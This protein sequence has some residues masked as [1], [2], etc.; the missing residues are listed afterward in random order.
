MEE[1]KIRIRGDIQIQLAQVG[2]ELRKVKKAL[3][4]LTADRPPSE[5]EALVLSH[6]DEALKGLRVAQDH[7]ELVGFHLDEINDD[8]TDEDPA[9]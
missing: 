8:A 6:A 7:A 1:S 3:E 5:A 9:F 2:Y 4:L